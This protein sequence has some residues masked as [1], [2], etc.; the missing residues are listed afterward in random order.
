MTILTVDLKKNCRSNFQKIAII[1][2]IIFYDVRIPEIFDSPGLIA[3]L[4]LLNSQKCDFGQ[5]DKVFH[6]CKIC[7]RKSY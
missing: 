6:M 7:M 2:I 1:I 5:H 3:G 4:A